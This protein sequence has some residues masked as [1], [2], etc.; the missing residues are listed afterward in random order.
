M[1]KMSVVIIQKQGRREQNHAD[2]LVVSSTSS[3]RRQRKPETMTVHTYGPNV[4]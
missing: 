1:K 2:V 3:G 4:L